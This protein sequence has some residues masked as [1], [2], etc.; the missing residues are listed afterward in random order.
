MKYSVQPVH[1]SSVST[2]NYEILHFSNSIMY[3]EKIQK[4]TFLKVNLYLNKMQKYK[5]DLKQLDIRYPSDS[6]FLKTWCKLN[7]TILLKQ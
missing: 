2:R 4:K 3:V 1:K 5:S 7:S 6:G